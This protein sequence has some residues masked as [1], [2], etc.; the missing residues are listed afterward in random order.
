[1]RACLPLPSYSVLRRACRA[2]L[3]LL[4][5]WAEA[6]FWSSTSRHRQAFSG[7]HPVPA[8]SVS[9]AHIAHSPQCSPP[10]IAHSLHKSTLPITPSFIPLQF[11]RR[12]LLVLSCVLR[13]S[14]PIHIVSVR[15]SFSALQRLSSL[16]HSPDLRTHSA[17]SSSSPPP[18]S[19][20]P[21]RQPNPFPGLSLFFFCINRT[22]RVRVASLLLLLPLLLSSSLDISWS[23]TSSARACELT[24]TLERLKA[25]LERGLEI[26]PPCGLALVFSP[27]FC[28]FCLLSPS[29]SVSRSGACPPTLPATTDHVLNLPLG[30]ICF[31][32]P[33]ALAIALS[34]LFSSFTSSLLLSAGLLHLLFLCLLLFVCSTLPSTIDKRPS[35][36]SPPDSTFNILI[37]LAS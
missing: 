13:D 20:P 17:S 33:P 2:V 19:V 6:R 34:V 7:S 15:S 9:S 29:P 16:S 5:T 28:F 27:L 35:S 21:V 31:A 18:L 10:N 12:P 30:P 1:M 22:Q 11:P 32:F 37:A 14:P 26:Q 8:A 4:A 24:R 36:I 23:I 3:L 25:N